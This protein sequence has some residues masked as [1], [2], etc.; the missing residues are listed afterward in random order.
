[1]LSKLKIKLNDDYSA[2]ACC[3][4]EG[5]SECTNRVSRYRM[6]SHNE[7]Y[8]LCDIHSE[9]RFKGED[10][11][12]F[13]PHI[14][15]IK[16]VIKAYEAALALTHFAQDRVSRN[17]LSHEYV[18]D[19]ER[20]FEQAEALAK[21]TMEIL[22]DNNI[23]SHKTIHDAAL[24]LYQ[25]VDNNSALHDLH[26]ISNNKEHYSLDLKHLA[27]Y[28]IYDSVSFNSYAKEKQEMTENIAYRYD[29]AVIDAIEKKYK[30]NIAKYKEKYHDE[31]DKNFR[32]SQ[33]LESKFT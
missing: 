16:S 18:I 33:D 11:E 7:Y 22:M 27:S 30:K 25:T 17:G 12:I 10:K 5:Q 14:E 31:K 29:E 13:V 21:R 6:I 32:V 24:K 26:R 28:S 2:F 1:M 15:M 9:V 19:T 4:L 8:L 23:S 20:Y 3:G